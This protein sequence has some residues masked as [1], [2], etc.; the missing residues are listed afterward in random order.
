LVQWA[1]PTSFA[2]HTLSVDLSE[3]YHSP[4]WSCLGCR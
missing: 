1:D 4:P 2:N 3:W